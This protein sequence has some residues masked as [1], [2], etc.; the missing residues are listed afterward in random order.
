MI[1][2]K[3]D[4]IALKIELLDKE[5]HIEQIG[6]GLIDSKKIPSQPFDRPELTANQR[7]ALWVLSIGGKVLLKDLDWVHFEDQLPTRDY[8]VTEIDLGT[9]L[10]V[11][12]EGL[13]N[14]SG[15]T[16]LDNAQFGLNQS[17][18]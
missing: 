3:G 16:E 15:L 10:L 1:I 6:K 11:T 12:D 13:K 17:L 4:A 8:Q 2:K 14:L 7:G 9:S 5:I 18:R